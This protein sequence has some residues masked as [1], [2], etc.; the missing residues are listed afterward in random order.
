MPPSKRR[1]QLKAARE[2]KRQKMIITNKPTILSP[3]QP[4][5][6]DYYESSDTEFLSDSTE[7]DYDSESGV[8]D[9]DDGIESPTR[10][11]LE[12]RN[13]INNVLK[14]KAGADS[15]LRGFYGAGSKTT[16]HRKALE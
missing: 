7:S 3:P 14:Y 10:D 15:Y 8:S 16:R 5:T 13:D 9:S 6:P 11:S 4:P 12:H 2:F 1:A